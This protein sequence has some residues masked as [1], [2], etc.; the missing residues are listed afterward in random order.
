MDTLH[1]FPIGNAYGNFTVSKV[2]D[3]YYWEVNGYGSDDL[4]E[5]PKSLYDE[6]IKFHNSL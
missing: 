6:L 3:S 4:Q 5:I 2:G 1:Q